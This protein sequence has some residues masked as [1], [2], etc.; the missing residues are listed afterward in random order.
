M[1]ALG[2]LECSKPSEC[3][4]SCTATKK[5][6]FP[7]G[8]RHRQREGVENTTRGGGPWPQH[9]AMRLLWWELLPVPLLPTPVH[10]PAP[11]PRLL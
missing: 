11:K 4:S 3:P 7:A 2:L 8:E 6:L 5:R 9:P 10:L 1:I